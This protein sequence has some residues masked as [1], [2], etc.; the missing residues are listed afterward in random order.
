[1]APKAK[2]IQKEFKAEKV[3]KGFRVKPLVEKKKNGNIIIRPASFPLIK[4]LKKQA[5]ENG[6]RNIQ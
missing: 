5:K 3:G 2:K 6:K 1:M 4:K